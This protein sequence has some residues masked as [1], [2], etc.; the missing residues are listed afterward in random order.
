M[1]GLINQQQPAPMQQPQPSPMAPGAGGAPPQAA[2][3]QGA[4]PAPG[5]K[6]QATPQELQQYKTF[7]DNAYKIFYNKQAMPGLLQRLAQGTDFVGNLGTVSAMVCLRVFDGMKQA[8]QQIDAPMLAQA[9]LEVT[10]EIADMA[11]H[12]N[13]H[14]FSPADIKAAYQ[15]TV[16]VFIHTL[17]QAGKLTPQQLQQLQQL[18][19]KG[20]GQAG[21]APAP[22]NGGIHGHLLSQ[23]HGMMPQ[24][25]DPGAPPPP[26]GQDDPNAPRPPMGAQ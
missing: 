13:V 14:T 20:G 3:P 26:D 17:A 2:G 19:Q 15:R 4:P 12:S 9:G 7:V 8:N 6:R 25:Q 16:T 22:S 23:V 11:K 5:Q 1:A 21:A 24:P 18:G 10:A